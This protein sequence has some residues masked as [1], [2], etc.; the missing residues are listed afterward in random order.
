MQAKPHLKAL[1]PVAP[2]NKYSS[3]SLP[4]CFDRATGENVSKSQLKTYL[5]GLAQYHLHSETK[6]LNG[7]YLNTDK[8]QRRH[9]IVKAIQ[10]IGKEANKWEEQFF[11]GMDDE[12]QIEY[13]LCPEQKPRC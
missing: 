2:Y 4:H 8:T 1:K 9:I 10:H 6:F 3:K 5:D 13:G 11:T 12:A 7:D